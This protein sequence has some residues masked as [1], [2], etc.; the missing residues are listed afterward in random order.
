MKKLTTA[1]L[2]ALAA[3]ISAPALRADNIEKP[4]ITFHTNIYNTYGP[5]NSFHIT[6]G[7]TEETYVDVDYGYGPTEYVIGASG[8]DQESGEL[9]GTPITMSVPEAGIV[10]I[11]CDAP[12]KIDY[13]D[14]EGCYISD[15]DWPEL[16]NV[17]ILNLRHN[18]FTALDLSHMTKL[19]AVYVDDNPCTQSTPFVL[20]DNHPDLVILSM[21][22]IDWVDPAFNPGKFPKLQ[23]LVCYGCPSISQL[24][25][26]GCP[27]L[28]QLSVDGTSIASLD[29]TKNPYL[30]ILNISETHITDIDVSQNAYLTELYAQH[31]ATL[32]NSYKLK[33]LDVSK[34]PE[35][36]R[37]YLNGN[38]LTELDISNNPKINSLGVRRNKLSGISFENNPAMAL[39]DIS[40]NYMD[41][42]TMPLPGKTLGE[43]NYEQYP[44][45]M[46]RSYAVGTT[47][48]FT[49]RV[50]RNDGSVTS[51]AVFAV[52]RENPGEPKILDPE[53]YT[54]DNGKLTLNKAFDTDSV[55]VAFH[56]SAFEDYDIVTTRFMVKEPGQMGK[57]SRAASF[58]TSSLVDNITLYVGLA[59]ATADNPKT[60][61]VDPGNGTM[62]E[63]TA[64]TSATPETPNV[65]TPRRGL[66]S[67]ISVPEGVDLTALKMDGMRM[68]GPMNIDGATKLRELTVTNCNLASIDTRW[69]RALHKVN[70]SGNVLTRLS[71]ESANNYYAKNMLSDVDVSNNKL[72]EENIVDVSGLERVNIANNRIKKVITE[73]AT[74]IVYLNAANNVIEEFE[75]D[76]CESLEYLDISGNNIASL[77]IP[78]ST[79]LKSLNISGNKFGLPDITLPGFC[80]DYTYAPQQPLWIA[81][82]SPS[83]NLSNQF[84]DINGETTRF[85]W[86][87]A[88]DNTK[89]KEGDIVDKGDGRFS[90]ANPESGLI[91]CTLTHPALPQ[92]AGDNV[93]RTTEVLT[94][95]KP[96]NV[97]ASMTTSAS[98]KALV[99]MTGKTDKTIVYADWTGEGDY[100]QYILSDTYQGFYAD[101][102]ADRTVNFY[103][104]DD[105]ENVTVFT[106]NGIPLKSVDISAMKSVYCFGLSGTGVSVD[107]IKFPTEAKLTE[108]VC[109]NCG[110]DRLPVEHL[111]YVENM[112]IGGNNFE[113]LDL[114]GMPNLK[115][116]SCPNGKVKEVKLN[117]PL[118]WNLEVPNNAISELDL[119]GA[120]AITQ[121]IVNG[122]FLK[123]LDLDCLRSLRV[124]LL[125]GNNFDIQTL[126]PVKDSYTVYNY[127]GQRPLQIKITDGKVDLSSQAERDGV[128]TQYTWFIGYPYIDDYGNLAGED[129]YENEEYTIENGVTSFLEAYKDVMC[130]MTNNLFPNLYLTTNFIDT[131]VAGIDEVMSDIESGTAVYYDLQG[132]RVDNPSRG[133]YVKVQDGKSSKVLVK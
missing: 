10:K 31:E 17:E 5:Y 14:F 40:K 43:Y 133:I 98:G 131:E 23:S 118:L 67:S 76:D 45:Q 95:D 127:N 113:T 62:L 77:N 130:V 60:F 84:M 105:N 120:P 88:S 47:L 86:R 21:H 101:V 11:Y 92:F 41:F 33:K 114:T 35:L 53:F 54:W 126:P 37:L 56:N 44:F 61:Y 90:F 68:N 9:T 52:Y 82:K 59:G 112:W 73:D 64:T 117:N 78:L 25:V 63:F 111:G 16:T 36:V 42:N 85:E 121:L 65:V 71:L 81:S 18:E 51:A 103:S 74:D 72:T 97:F 49:G 124:V 24:D 132:R 100:E 34:N 6:L 129:L 2:V 15:I 110:F 128:K 104:Y 1:L 106:L 4:A 27:Y 8:F 46:E 99:T 123:E 29:V 28:K 57:P 125:G 122:N 30:L 91:Y 115:Y 89:V 107:N 75:I 69:N 3:F 12:D 87:Y 94:A 119:S 109:D 79:H 39:V 26:T 48:D 83:I 7:A 70:L 80:D 96:T 38:E 22:T 108:F 50:I 20:G 58:M 32:N 55:Y 66:N 102:E 93:F 116:L 13:I 19:A